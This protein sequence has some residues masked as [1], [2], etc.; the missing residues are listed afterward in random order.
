MALPSSGDNLEFY[1][2]DT[3][4][5]TPIDKMRFEE[6]RTYRWRSSFNAP[7]KFLLNEI[8]LS[9]VRTEIGWEGE[10]MAPFQSGMLTFSI[11][12][13]ERVTVQTYLYSDNRKLTETDFSH[14]IVDI[15]SEA[16]AC[17]QHCGAHLKFDNNGFVRKV[18]LAQWDYIDRNFHR[19]HRIFR[20]IQAE[21]LRK[22][23]ASEQWIRRENVKHVTPAL[24]AWSERHAGHGMSE[25]I[26]VPELIW[27][28]VREE[29]FNVFENQVLLRQLRDL[30]RLLR[31][32]QTISIDAIRS[33]AEQY[34]DRVHYWLRSSFLQQIQP[35]IG[36]VVISQAFRKHPVYR[37]WFSWF[38]ELYQFNEYSIGFKSPIPLKDT[39]QLYEIWVFMQIVKILRENGAVL[40][41]SDLFALEQDGLVLNLSEKK[42]SRI[43]MVGGATLAYQRWFTSATQDFVTYTHGMKPDIVLEADGKLYIFDP[44]Y[45]LDHNLPM[46]L[47]EM[48]KY[49]DGIVSKTNRNRVVE[50]VFI[51]TPAPGKENAHLFGDEYRQQYQ[52]GAYWL[53]P[54]D[55]GHELTNKLAEIISDQILT[56]R[57]N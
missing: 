31:E 27:S 11:E 19:L 33:K 53:K 10:W 20:Q 55:S 15:L 7:F 36:P 56:K 22:L 38:H 52:M 16:A 1:C 47:G 21:P 6:A 28:G 46:A 43:K 54:G 18:S 51:I 48:H 9:M 39:Y 3:G 12:H 25:G 44:K 14:M 24:L 45:R 57:T 2:P 41:T 40:D 4:T 29:T 30:L 35:H 13:D 23:R 26:P 42:E 5:W 32:Y 8:P 34:V 49:R 50:E 17:F 37:N